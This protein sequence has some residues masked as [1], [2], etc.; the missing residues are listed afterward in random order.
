MKNIKSL[1][2]R[3]CANCGHDKAPHLV[4]VH[5]PSPVF[6]TETT[7]VLPCNCPKYV[8]AKRRIK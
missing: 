7:T 6:H 2:L 3:Q 4:Y 5:C 1:C 8:E